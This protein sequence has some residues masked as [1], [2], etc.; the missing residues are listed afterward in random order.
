LIKT[1]PRIAKSETI[2]N[3]RFKFRKIV[4]NHDKAGQKNI[5]SP[6]LKPAVFFFAE[7][8]HSLRGK[9]ILTVCQK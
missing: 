9:E 1:H 4:K 6:L 2:R 7:E 5:F 3:F 8:C